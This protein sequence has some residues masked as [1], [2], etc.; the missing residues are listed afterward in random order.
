MQLNTIPPLI[1][2]K[3][4]GEEATQNDVK[5]AKGEA[6]L[7]FTES[8][9]IPFVE[10]LETVPDMACRTHLVYRQ[11][12]N[13]GLKCELKGTEDLCRWVVMF[14][15]G[16]HYHCKKQ[17]DGFSYFIIKTERVAYVCISTKTLV[18][19]GG[20]SRVSSACLLKFSCQEG[21]IRFEGAVEAVKHVTPLGKINF[22]NQFTA[23]RALR[24]HPFVA[25]PY[26]CALYRG[27][28]CPQIL[29]VFDRF[30]GELKAAPKEIDIRWITYQVG[31][32]LLAMH[33]E[34]FIHRDLKSA[35]ILW[36]GLTKIA[37]ADLG[38]CCR[39]EDSD[40]QKMAR[41][42]LK[43]AAP[44]IA[45]HVIASVAKKRGLQEIYRM[46]KKY[47]PLFKFTPAMDMW[48][49]G[50]I[51]I[52]RVAGRPQH[53]TVL[54]KNIHDATKTLKS[55]EATVEEK[56]TALTH[57]VQNA[58]EWIQWME[59]RLEV[60]KTWQ[61]LP[62]FTLKSFIERSLSVDPSKRPTDN[63]LQALIASLTPASDQTTQS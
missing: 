12:K 9:P 3:R 42:T 46:L 39:V 32:A 37:L 56:H 7:P 35:N 34:G 20:Y 25:T 54:L 47:I 45:I 51:L 53:Y 61:P 4:P 28:K 44:E 29:Q 8:G 60:E 24:S 41:G 11:F 26:F 49:L 63:Q 15:P 52:E 1:T 58:R 43:Y 33:K 23:H 36:N 38:L 50:L 21:E 48:G 30:Q 19:K 6:P 62:S 14:Q 17:E 59:G 40:L 10:C 27:K 55:E 16:D 2:L 18:G 57:F 13:L 22:N 31:S 5:K